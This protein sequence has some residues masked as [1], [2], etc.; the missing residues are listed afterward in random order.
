[1]KKLLFTVNPGIGA[2]ATGNL[3]RRPE[4]FTQRIF[5]NSLNSQRVDLILPTGIVFPMVSYFE[6]ISHVSLAP[7]L[8]WRCVVI[9]SCFQKLPRYP[10]QHQYTL[11][12]LQTGRAFLTARAAG[13]H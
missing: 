7:K 3:N 4:E 9:G 5:N 1:M 10:A 13:W 8:V 6:E 2:A 11:L 12:P